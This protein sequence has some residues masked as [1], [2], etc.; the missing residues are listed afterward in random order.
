MTPIYQHT[1]DDCLRA[2]V[3][4]ILE[5]SYKTVPHFIRES[6]NLWLDK[7]NKWISTYNIVCINISYWSDYKSIFKDIYMI[8]AGQSKRFP[9][10][11]HAVVY[12]NGKEVHD[13]GKNTGIVGNPEYFIIFALK[14]PAKIIR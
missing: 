4:S 10:L 6:E 8:A 3:A 5:V 7:L 2:C 12:Y 13:P 1:D 11:D 9:D 14:D